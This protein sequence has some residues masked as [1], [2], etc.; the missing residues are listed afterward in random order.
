MKT[1]TLLVVVMSLLSL[2]LV[3]CA[4]QKIEVGKT[5]GFL[6]DYSGMTKGTEEQLGM[7]Y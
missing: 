3:A 2:L 7:V 1:R 5:S 4:A 6:S